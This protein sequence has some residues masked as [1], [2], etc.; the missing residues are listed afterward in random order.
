MQIVL[1]LLL[2]VVFAFVGLAVW[3]ASDRPLA[4]REIAI[5]TRRDGTGGPDYVL[6]RVLAVLLK[7]FAVL[8]WNTGLFLVIYVNLTDA[9]SL[10]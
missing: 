6:L 5:N 1:T 8:L 4:L 3:A 10:L 9:L 2:I 7:V